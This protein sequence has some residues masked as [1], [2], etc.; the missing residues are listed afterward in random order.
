MKYYV[1]ITRLE[2][3]LVEPLPRET[4]A[5]SIVNEGCDLCLFDYMNKVVPC[6]NHYKLKDLVLVWRKIDLPAEADNVVEF[7]VPAETTVPVVPETVP[8]LEAVP[9]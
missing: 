6:K 3:P 1:V 9:A 4:K 2:I 7:V 8:E 5:A